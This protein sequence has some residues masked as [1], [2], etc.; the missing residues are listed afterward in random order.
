M[1]SIII[2]AKKKVLRVGAFPTTRTLDELMMHK[3]VPGLHAG[4]DVTAH[5]TIR[6]PKKGIVKD[7][8]FQ[9]ESFVANFLKL[10][11]KEMRADYGY[12]L[13]DSNGNIHSSNGRAWSSS[14]FNAMSSDANT[15]CFR[16]PQIGVGT[17]APTPAD[18]RMEKHLTHGIAAQNLSAATGVVSSASKTV[19]NFEV[20]PNPG[21]STDQWKHYF[22]RMD[23]GP[24]AG[25][26]RYILGNSNN[27]IYLY[28][29]GDRLT[30][31][32]AIPATGNNF[33][34]LTYGQVIH[35]SVGITAPVDDGNVTS[36]MTVTRTFTNSTGGSI[37]VSEFGFQVDIVTSVSSYPYMS[38]LIIRDTQVAVT[39]L[40]TQEMTV[41]YTFTV[42]A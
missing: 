35:G 1:S 22:L 6:D 19:Y 29:Y 16:G 13:V 38:I 28:S 26:I 41:T 39:L 34:I 20:T 2:P 23:D 27:D 42:V 8:D 32:S 4:I 24:A 30:S 37:D 36:T 40:N 18:H 7:Y 17:T 25:D 9:C 12:G 33:T 21:W 5:V 14:D 31:L 15:F 3:T 10:L 11:V